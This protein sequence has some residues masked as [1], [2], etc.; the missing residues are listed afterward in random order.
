MMDD[1]KK[2]KHGKIY[3]L[4]SS[5][6][7]ETYIGSTYM[8]LTSRLVAHKSTAKKEVKRRVYAHF[9]A[10]GWDSVNI[11]LIENFECYTRDQL[12]RRETSWIQTLKPS[13]NTGKPFVN[14][15]SYMECPF[16]KQF[17]LLIES[18]C[19]C[20]TRQMHYKNNLQNLVRIVCC[21]VNWILYNCG[22]TKRLLQHE[23]CD[24][25]EN[26]T[27]AET[28][29]YLFSVSKALQ[30]KMPKEHAVW[31]TFSSELCLDERLMTDSPVEANETM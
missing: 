19:A 18:K 16:L 26:R 12:E 5:R 9:N 25:M 28:I 17:C 8:P 24:R 1:Y 11:E 31:I 10:L 2:Y 4:V 20:K 21:D 13:L 7:Q 22:K 29:L 14:R 23:G 6:N 27:F 15:C 30:V 3:K